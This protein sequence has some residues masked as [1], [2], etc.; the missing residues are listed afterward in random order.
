[1]TRNSLHARHR[2]VANIV[3]RQ[4]F[5]A[6]VHRAFEMTTGQRLAPNWHVDHV[7]NYLQKMHQGRAPGE[8]VV[9]L[10]PRSLKSFIISIC[11]PAWRLGLDPTAKI[12]CASYSEDL[13]FK[14][15][16][17][18]RA[19]M[20]TR[21]Y[22][23]VFPKARLSRRKCTE[24]EFETTL[25][26][27]RV[28]TSVGGTLTGR[29]GGMLIVDD[30][31]KAIDAG[32]PAALEAA[33]EWFANTA[34]SRF[35]DLSRR[36]LI[37]VMQRLHANDLSG[38]LIERGWPN[39]V[40]PAIATEDAD[41]ET[42][43]GQFYHRPKGEVL[44]P[45]RD[46][47]D[48]IQGLERSVGSRVFQ[49]QYQQDPVPP[50]GNIFKVAWIKRY[51]I[52]PLPNPSAQIVMSWDTASK[53][54]DSNDYSVGTVWASIGPNY[55]LLDVVRGRWKFPGLLRT[56]IHTAAT[57]RGTTILVEDATS[58]T[59][60]IQ[61]LHLQTK[62]NVIAIKPKLDKRVR[63]EQQ[64]ATFEA[65]RVHLPVAASWLAGFESELLGFPSARHDDQ[66][67]S[68]VQIL[69]WAAARQP[70]QTSFHVPFVA[71]RPRIF[72]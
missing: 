8:L 31:N 55:Y 15:S 45:A 67:D 65:G 53:I 46:R 36:L 40:L 9:N 44:Q 38:I 61:S 43:E 18:C 42:E 33:N 63:A 39:I 29:G 57:H 25:G 16:R 59:A 28:A 20:E 37:V 41:Y 4:S 52:S 58:G 27:F 50:E 70:S 47:L 49:A 2:E 10:P 68:A 72:P 71:T 35:D 14:L 12:I 30:P 6:F 24:G 23:L 60:V 21:F 69:G 66:V 26:G 56:I 32:S 48:H 64:S 7:C 1:M 62:L 11:F 17:D 51:P 34:Q 19:L 22:S 5:V 3:Y 54:G 13:A